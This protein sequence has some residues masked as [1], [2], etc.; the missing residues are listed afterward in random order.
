MKNKIL[1][2]LIRFAEVIEAEG[3]SDSIF[4]IQLD[5]NSIKEI[6]QLEELYEDNLKVTTPNLSERLSN[7]F[8][9]HNHPVDIIHETEKIKMM[10][11]INEQETIIKYL[12]NRI[13]TLK[14]G[15][16]MPNEDFIKFIFEHRVDGDG[17]LML[18]NIIAPD[19]FKGNVNF[20]HC[21]VPKN[22]WQSFQTA[23]GNII[24]DHQ[25]AG[26]RIV[27]Y[28]QKAENIFQ[29]DLKKEEN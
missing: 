8:R 29:D 17:D 20:S 6:K 16:F 9:K 26:G 22:I 15:E 10:R 2:D 27:Q 1:K 13:P 24:Q 28:S 18:N 25:Q 21:V 23:G 5:Q 7:Y 14:P 19:N 3:S 11:T 12:Q 4:N